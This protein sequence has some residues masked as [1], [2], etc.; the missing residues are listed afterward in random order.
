MAAPSNPLTLY[1][2]V[3]SDRLRRHHGASWLQQPQL[4]RLDLQ[5][6]V[7]RVDAALGQAPGDEPEAGLRRL[8][9]HVTQLLVL[10]EAPDRADAPGDR[11]A[12][13]P[14]HQLLLALVARCQYD[15]VR[16]HG[17]AGTQACALS[18]EPVDVGELHEPYRA[19]DQEVR[20]ANIEVVAAAAGEVLELPARA[21]VAEGEPEAYL[22]EAVEQHLVHLAGAL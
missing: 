16:R 3:G 6:E 19:I 10:A 11:L 5:C 4:R 1:L 15:E 12:E 13:Q 14:A 20:A 8:H 7:L 9:E 2:G 18:H 21:V 22:F 17:F